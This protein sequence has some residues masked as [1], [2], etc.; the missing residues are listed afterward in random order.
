MVADH[1]AYVDADGTQYPANFPKDQI[2][3]LKHVPETPMDPTPE[4][5]Q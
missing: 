4:E 2:P 1:D 5:I 3:G